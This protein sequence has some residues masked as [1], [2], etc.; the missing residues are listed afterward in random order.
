MD[1]E[2][3]R[4]KWPTFSDETLRRAAGSRLVVEALKMENEHERR[5][6]TDSR[7]A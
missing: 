4:A 3:V 7:T 5:D 2:T 6:E 1:I